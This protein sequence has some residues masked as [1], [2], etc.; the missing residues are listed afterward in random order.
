M[1][2]L[3]RH[4]TSSTLIRAQYMHGTTYV[5][6]SAVSVAGVNCDFGVSSSL[7]SCACAEPN[8]STSL[9]GL[10]MKWQKNCRTFGMQ[11]VKIPT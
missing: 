4:F 2:Y 7:L 10:K 9:E 1:P 11:V 8:L 6:F 3:Q 5:G